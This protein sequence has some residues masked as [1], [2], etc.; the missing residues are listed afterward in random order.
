MQVA[1]ALGTLV[2]EINHPAFRDRVIT[3][4]SDPTWFDLSDC[5]GKIVKKVTK[6]RHAPW[7]LNTDLEKAFQLILDVVV[8][9]KLPVDEVPDL[10]IFSDMQFDSAV[11]RDRQKTTET[12]LKRIQNMFHDAGDIFLYALICLLFCIIRHPDLWHSLPRAKDRL[13]ESERRYFRFPSEERRLQRAAAKRFLAQ[14]AQTRHGGRG[15][16]REGSDEGGGRENG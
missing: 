16:G 11:S 9:N 2:S 13:L 10:I 5:E 6:L 15:V 1:I 7:G 8:D 3:F 12:Q 4:H 14:S